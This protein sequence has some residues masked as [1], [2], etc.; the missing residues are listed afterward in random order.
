[1][2][3]GADGSLTA[4]SL[5]LHASAGACASARLAAGSAGVV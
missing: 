5:E 3:A 4:F 1:M 2:S